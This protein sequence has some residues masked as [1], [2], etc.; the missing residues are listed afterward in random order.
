[1]GLPPVFLILREAV[2]KSRG[3]SVYFWTYFSLTDVTS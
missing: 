3:A 1:M 2:D